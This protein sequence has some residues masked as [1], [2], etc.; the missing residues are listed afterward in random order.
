MTNKFNNHTWILNNNYPEDFSWTDLGQT[1]VDIAN[2]ETAGIVKSSTDQLKGK[3]ENGIIS[4][5]GL[6]TYINEKISQS[7]GN[8]EN[9]LGDTEDLEV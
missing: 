1:L 4:I 2:S 8:I 3:I 9:L 5:N 6:E 7:I